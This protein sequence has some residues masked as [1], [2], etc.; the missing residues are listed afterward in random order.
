MHA[1]GCVL[2]YGDKR[3]T[4]LITYTQPDQSTIAHLRGQHPMKASEPAAPAKWG[5]DIRGDDELCRGVQSGG[6]QG[7]CSPQEEKRKPGEANEG[8]PIIIIIIKV[9]LLY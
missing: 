6:G 1:C 4:I 7:R 3:L 9:L 2:A 8:T 5:A